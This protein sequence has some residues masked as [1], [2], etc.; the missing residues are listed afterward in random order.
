MYF[1]C[2]FFCAVLFVSV[3]QMTGSGSGS[4]CGNSLG[5]ER[6]DLD[7]VEWDVKLY[8]NS[9]SVSH[10]SIETQ[11]QYVRLITTR[12]IFY[13]LPVRYCAY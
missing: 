8:P 13:F 6:N 1:V 5:I 3:Y 12:I 11:I 10:C 4:G 7:C 9:K 2:V